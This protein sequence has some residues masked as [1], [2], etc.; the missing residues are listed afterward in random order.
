[1]VIIRSGCVDDEGARRPDIE[2]FTDSKVGWV[3]EVEGAEYFG[4][5][6]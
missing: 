5:A 2:I 6:A 1:M 4:K 3:E